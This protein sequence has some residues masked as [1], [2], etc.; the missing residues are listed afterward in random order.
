MPRAD[1]LDDIH[2]RILR[3]TEDLRVIQQE[4]NCAVMEAPGDPELME[5]LNQLPEMESLEVLKSAMDQMRHFLW[6]YNQ[7]ITD[8]TD[9]GDSLRN[10]IRQGVSQDAAL[11]P[12]FSAAQKFNQAT[13]TILWQHL[14]DGKNRKPN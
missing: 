3:V 5:M 13:E 8:G 10:I 12:R 7:V 6:F 9:D 1:Y 4:L 14:L 2:L 11:S